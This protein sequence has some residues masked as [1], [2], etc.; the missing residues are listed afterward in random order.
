MNLSRGLFLAM[1]LTIVL[2]ISGCVAPAAAP[3][4]EAAAPAEASE[5]MTFEDLVVGFSQIG[6]ESDWRTANTESIKEE[7]ESAGFGW[8]SP[9]LSRNRRT[10]SRRCVRSSPRG[11]T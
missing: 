6:A 8:C 2:V 9:M 7:A 3:A 11:S 1:A 5:S 10:R 4:E